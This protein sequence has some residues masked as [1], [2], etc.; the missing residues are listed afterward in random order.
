MVGFYLGV[1][2][3]SKSAFNPYPKVPRIVKRSILSGYEALF[4]VFECGMVS[5]GRLLSILCMI[6][7]RTSQF[8]RVDKEKRR[9]VG[10]NDVSVNH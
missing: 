2:W 6:R 10:F 1:K 3:T 8:V 4:L 5:F 7:N 9:K